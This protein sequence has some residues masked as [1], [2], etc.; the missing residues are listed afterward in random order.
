[1]DAF[2]K[3]AGI[4]SILSLIISVIA[5][6]KVSKLEA[7]IKI[8]DHSNHVT[9]S[10]NRISQKAKGENISQAGGDMNV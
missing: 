7:N 1:M 9:N 4:A 2:N 3:I 10:H 8:D 6:K 5:I